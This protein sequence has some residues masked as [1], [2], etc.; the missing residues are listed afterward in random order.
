MKKNNIFFIPLMVVLGAIGVFSSASAAGNFQSVVYTLSPTT[1]IVTN[2]ITHKAQTQTVDPDF[3][4]MPYRITSAWEGQLTYGLNYSTST[5]STKTDAINATLTSLKNCLNIAYGPAIGTAANYVA[6]QTGVFRTQNYDP[7]W[8]AYNN[9]FRTKSV[10]AVAP[11]SGSYFFVSNANTCTV[12][13]VYN[14]FSRQVDYLGSLPETTHLRTLRCYNSALSGCSVAD[15]VAPTYKYNGDLNVQISSIDGGFKL[16]WND[17]S[18]AVGVV[19]SYDVLKKDN[20]GNYSV[21]L[22][23]PMITGTSFTDAHPDPLKIQYYQVNAY[24]SNNSFIGTAFVDTST[25]L[26]ISNIP[27]TYI[28]GAGFYASMLDSAVIS[29]TNNSEDPSFVIPC[30][31]FKYQDENTLVDGVCNIANAPSGVYDMLLKVGSSTFTLPKGFTLTY[32][33]PTALVVNIVPGSN[34]NDGM[35]KI[36]SVQGN[37]YT[38]AI[39]G[40]ESGNTRGIHTYT[41]ANFDSATNSFCADTACTAGNPIEFDISDV[42]R[43]VNG[44]LSKIQ[45]FVANDVGSLPAIYS[46]ANGNPL[47]LSDLGLSCVHNPD[48]S[49]WIQ[50]WSPAAPS[51]ICPVNSVNAV[52]NCGVSTSTSGTLACTAPQTSCDSI[53][54]QCVCT[55]LTKATACASA[56]WECSNGDL[57]PDG[58]GGTI[59]CGNCSFTCK[60]ITVAGVK[61]GQTCKHCGTDHQ[62]DN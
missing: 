46:D 57:L 33:V 7:A 47:S 1:I 25:L 22:T 32:P 52:D 27:V 19:V 62:C 12:T 8:S 21:Q 42:L 13:S 43:A 51:S 35:L 34:V 3:T 56:G 48:T 36:N 6:T 39:I 60:D 4:C 58:C 53:T 17:L 44:D 15:A 29:M 2:P 14:G 31:G 24:N 37:L 54:N 38:G 59:D 20:S 30:S 9:N 50:N 23:N 61:V 49:T 45:I 41:L 40:V 55:P 28:K 11:S 5:F 16:T 10:C 26:P 18:A